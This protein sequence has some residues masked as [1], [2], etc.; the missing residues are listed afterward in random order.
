MGELDSLKVKQVRPLVQIGQESVMLELGSQGRQVSLTLDWLQRWG[1]TFCPKSS[2]E[3]NSHRGRDS[4]ARVLERL[5]EPSPYRK[6][7][8]GQFPAWLL[9]FSCP[10][11]GRRCMS[12][13]A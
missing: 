11:C 4:V 6:A 9:Y 5:D 3:A 1:G 7:D 12:S 8:R 2:A 13:T 10:K